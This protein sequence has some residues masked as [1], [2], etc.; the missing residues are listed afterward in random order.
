L[1]PTAKKKT[2]KV[3][4]ATKADAKLLEVVIDLC[5]WLA[6]V[7]ERVGKLESAVRGLQ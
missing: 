1:T 3:A 2:G 6:K 4:S 7:S 5:E